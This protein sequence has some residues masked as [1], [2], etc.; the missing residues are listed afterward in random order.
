MQ[1]SSLG[2]E[3]NIDSN[4]EFKLLSELGSADL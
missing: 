2:L 3:K 4:C 1:I